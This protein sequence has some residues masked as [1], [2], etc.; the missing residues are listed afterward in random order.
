VRKEVAKA[1][2]RAPESVEVMPTYLGGG[3]GRKSGIEPAVEAARLAQAAG[4]PVH[5]GWNRLEDMRHGYVRPPTHHVLRAALDGAGRI[6]AIE[7]Q[8]ASGEVAFGFIPGFLAAIMGADFGAWRGATIAYNAPHTRA[9]A[10]RNDL[11]LAT[12]WWRGLGLLANVF[13][14]ESF[15]DELAHA[16]GRDPLQF[17]LDNLPDDERGARLRAVLQ[18]AAERAGWNSPAPAGHSRGVAC[19][20]DAKTAVAEIAEVSVEGQT[21]RVHRV[22]AAVDPG[23]VINPDGATAQ[24]QG[25]I[26]MG[27]SST[28]F[29]EL[30]IKDGAIVPANFDAYP[31]LTMADTPEIEVALAGSGDTPYGMGEPPIGPIAAAVANAIFAL[32]GQR[33]RRLPL[34]L[35]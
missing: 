29:E 13:A 2:G 1:L 18:L 27:L 4:V 10:W 20:M 11:P 28:L 19:C 12:G 33:L 14:I 3:F 6:T 15:V 24:T 8:Q 26:V 17:R 16:A 5:V 9:V 22:T 31:L 34:R 32:T 23:L 35:A 30:T 7:H 25:A 21:I